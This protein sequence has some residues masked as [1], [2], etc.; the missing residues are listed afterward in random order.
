M[1]KHLT[2]LHL[3][4]YIVVVVHM[5]LVAAMAISVPLLAIHQPWYVSLP[6]S[7]WIMHLM[8]AP[9]KCPLTTLENYI[10]SELHLPKIRGF[11]SHYFTWR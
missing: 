4:L 7:V 9:L 1:I 6:V 2:F 10:R 11:I 3:A 8:K 5:V